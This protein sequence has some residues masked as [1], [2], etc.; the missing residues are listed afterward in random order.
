MSLHLQE[1]QKI[2]KV[3]YQFF[4]IIKTKYYTLQKTTHQPEDDCL[5]FEEF[6]VIFSPK[7]MYISTYMYTFFDP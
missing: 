3:L 4:L 1:I 6:S 7:Y 5:G 2:Q